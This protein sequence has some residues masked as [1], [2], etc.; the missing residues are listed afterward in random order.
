MSRSPQEIA[1]VVVR[2]S[3]GVA[4]ANTKPT[5][6][7]SIGPMGRLRK[8]A[9]FGIV[10]G[11]MSLMMASASAPSPF[12]PVLQREFGFSDLMMTSIFGIYAI[13]LLATLLVAGS[14][15]DHV[16]RRLVLSIGFLLLASAAFLLWQ[17]GSVS[18]LLVA[19]VVQGVACGL[20][21]STLSAAVV[22]LEPPEH[23]GSAAVWNSVLPFAGLAVGALA[24]GAI[25]DFRPEPKR[26]VFGGLLVLCLAF[27]FAV[28]LPPET[29]P[30]HE[31]I[32]SALRPRLGLPVS[33]R[34]AFWGAAPAIFAGWA[35]GGFY[36]SL[37]ASVSAHVFNIADYLVQAGVIALLSGTAA[38]AC[39][40]ATRCQPRQVTLYGTAALA[41]G[42][43][44]TIAGIMSQSLPLYVF[45]LLIAGTGFG[46]CFY[47]A[48]RTLVPLA[49]AGE[50]SELF[51][52]I[53]TL[54]YLAF[55]VPTVLAGVL[56]PS[57][58]LRETASAY[59]AVI[60]VLAAIAGIWRK[61]G[62]A[63]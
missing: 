23:P 34:A 4:V 28:W 59:G 61:F 51:A 29:A 13:S 25:M 5:P 41:T 21:L 7:Q 6:S 54:S 16:G 50:R 46:T 20:L 1:N 24:S 39:F 47:G 38:A 2:R 9:G 40:M 22:D 60:V 62:A 49:A 17:A 35:T 53:F 11:G 63:D 36:L 42:T 45:S 52:S 27:G 12:Y 57:L 14:F 58:G 48:L 10:L 30:R 44:F 32:W 33:A 3:A 55:G 8:R 26:E 15:S 31:G 43:I 19:R 18:G 37:S 56:L